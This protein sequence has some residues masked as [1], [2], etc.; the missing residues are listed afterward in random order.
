MRTRGRPRSAAADS[1]IVETVLRLLEEGTTLG[2]LSMERI[3]RSAG[4]GKATVY[5][6]W[7]NK[8]ALLMDVVRAVDE[9]LPPLAGSSVRDDLVALL[10]V[11]RRHASA[12]RSSAVL[13]TVIGHAQH[14]PELWRRYHDTVVRTRC[15]AMCAVLRRGVRTGEIRDDLDVRLLADLFAGPVLA[16]ALLCERACLEDG[17]AE[18]IVDA[19]LDGVRPGGRTPV[20]PGS[21][22]RPG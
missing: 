22:V 9:P 5:R 10:E 8:D 7:A 2:E 18:R 19:V 6:R 1:S 12:E 20:R 16:R 11:T 4:V 17:L 21:P 13:R 3:A 14:S 15:E